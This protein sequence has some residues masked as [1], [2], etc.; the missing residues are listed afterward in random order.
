MDKETM[1]YKEFLLQ[2]LSSIAES[3]NKNDEKELNQKVEVSNDGTVITIKV[4]K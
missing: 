4:L 3:L 1:T 2:E